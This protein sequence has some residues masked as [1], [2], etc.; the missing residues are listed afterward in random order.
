MSKRPKYLDRLAGTSKKTS[1]G[2]A[3]SSRKRHEISAAGRMA[4]EVER[5]SSQ[6]LPSGVPLV[7]AACPDNPPRSSRRRKRPFGAVDPQLRRELED[8]EV[9]SREAPARQ[10][11]R[12]PEGSSKKLK[13]SVILGV[14]DLGQDIREATSHL[15][16]AFNELAKAVPPEKV[17]GYEDLSPEEVVAELCS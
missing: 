9:P 4:V 11:M 1:P 8:E 6:G 17:S 7:G 3:G 10:E 16:P 15:V 2:G 5:P 13:G 14:D 12:A